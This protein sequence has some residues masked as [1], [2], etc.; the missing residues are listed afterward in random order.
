[1]VHKPATYDDLARLPPHVIGEIVR[2]E[3]VVSPR[4]AAHHAHA[5]S[6]LGMDLGSPFQRGRGGPGGYWILDEP[7]LHRGTNVLVP[8]LAGW[9]RKRMP[10]VPD[11]PF[12]TLA[13]DW[14]CEVTSPSTASLDRVRKMPLYA[15]AGVTYVWLVDPRERLLEAHRRE[16]TPWL[17]IAAHSD[18]ERV[19]VE[20]F[21]AAELELSALWSDGSLPSSSAPLIPALT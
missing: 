14:L 11:V 3:L 18:D 5:A 2:G 7:E 1:M 15:E 21:E 6:V 8:D 20:P 12:F 16:G 4:P 13:P 9:H 19:R 17:R 10:V